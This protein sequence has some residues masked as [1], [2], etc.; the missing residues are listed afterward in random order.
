VS[1]VALQL[2]TVRGEA[3]NDLAGA[4]AT[5]AALGLDGVELHDLYGHSAETVRELLD[6]NGLV[7]CGC[8]VGLARVE[9]ELASVAAELRTLGTDRLVVPWVEQP[10]TAAAADETCGR[11][12]AA[13]ERAA[14]LGLRFGF[15]NHD[16]ELAALEDGRTLLDRLLEV[17]AAL[18]YLELD[19][20]WVWYAGG[21]P[22]T[23]LER[24]GERAPLIH[25]KDMLRDGGPVH[26]PLGD[27][28]L[29]YR[30]FREVVGQAGSEWLILEQDETEGPVFAAVESSIAVLRQ[31]LAGPA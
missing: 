30:R 9:N 20:G 28:D 11:L 13:A 12:V 7:V 23:F 14:A 6:G 19:L 24:L 4:L 10:K 1:R 8:H 31:L 22:M 16:G 17:P 15:H 25:V 27:G 21:D 5:T 29:D 2:Y 3:A 26:V 18:L